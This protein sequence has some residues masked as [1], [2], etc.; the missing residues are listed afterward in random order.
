MRLCKCKLK[1]EKLTLYFTCYSTPK[2]LAIGG[3]HLR[4][5]PPAKYSRGKEKKVFGKFP[6]LPQKRFSEEGLSPG[7]LGVKN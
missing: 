6:L 7:E 1:I 3:A 5:I 4:V 2:R